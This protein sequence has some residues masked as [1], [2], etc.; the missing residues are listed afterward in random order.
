MPS[1]YEPIATTTLGS[2][3]A[4]VTFSSIT[5]S[6]TDLIISY[7][8]TSSIEQQNFLRFNGDTGSNYSR[9]F[10]AGDG[11]SATSNRSSNGTSLLGP[12]SV[13]VPTVNLIQIQNYSN[14]TT[15]KTTLIRSGAANNS[16]IATVGLYRSTSAIT[17]V[18][19]STTAGTFDS[20]TVFTVYG[21][22]SA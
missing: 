18:L 8:A 11:S 19:I 4:S 22:K 12:F 10:M 20:G 5:G 9:T 2:A 6:Y 15:F 7:N 1:T 21:I 14:T 13:F 16:T 3:Q 17:S